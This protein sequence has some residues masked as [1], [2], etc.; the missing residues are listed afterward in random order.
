MV[1][2]EMFAPHSGKLA[3]ELVMIGRAGFT[4]SV[5][6]HGSTLR[7]LWREIV[8]DAFFPSIHVSKDAA[9]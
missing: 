6:T 1:S 7:R 2:R 4:N 8:A 3:F 5:A 9:D